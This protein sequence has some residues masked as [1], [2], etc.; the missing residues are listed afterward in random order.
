MKFYT[1]EEFQK[2]WDQLITNVESGEII[3]ITNGEETAIL[4]TMEE[5]FEEELVRIYTE[6]NDAS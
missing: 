1:V 4:T 2:H 6:H 3:G 5:E